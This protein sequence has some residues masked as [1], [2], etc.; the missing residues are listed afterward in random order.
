MAV[1]RA[2][3]K[4]ENSSV[5]GL[6]IGF[7]LT[8]VHI[9]GIAFIGTSVNP[10]RSFGPDIFAGG[11]ALQSVWLLIVTPLIGVALESLLYKAIKPKESDEKI[12]K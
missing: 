4:E 9:L 10:D 1:L 5:A 2:T 8:L 6:V 12:S 7:S 11:N 3:D